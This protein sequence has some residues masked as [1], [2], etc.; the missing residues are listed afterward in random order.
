MQ[1]NRSEACNRGGLVALENDRN[2]RPVIR[3]KYRPGIRGLP[4]SENPGA[5]ARCIEDQPFLAQDS[6]NGRGRSFRG[7][8]N[9]ALPIGAL[10]PPA[11][12]LL[13]RGWIR[14]VHV[15]V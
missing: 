5:L 8:H 12:C 11:S 7:W 6:C 15:S 14:H 3:E 9:V 13:E 1:T 2:H 4:G 10:L